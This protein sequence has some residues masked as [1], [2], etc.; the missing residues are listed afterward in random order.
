MDVD[1]VVGP[2]SAREDVD[3]D[4]VIHAELDESALSQTVVIEVV[5]VEGPGQNLAVLLNQD[6][7]VLALELQRKFGQRFQL[8]SCA[9]EEHYLHTVLAW[10]EK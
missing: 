8:F 2:H 4:L 3:P 1:V 10:K 9:R 5:S 7:A 6:E